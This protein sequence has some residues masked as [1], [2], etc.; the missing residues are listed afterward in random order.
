MSVFV[1]FLAP[2]AWA[3]PSAE[4]L[5]SQSAFRT[6]DVFQEVKGEP[7][8]RTLGSSSIHGDG[9]PSSF[10][11]E[12][13]QVTAVGQKA[14]LQNTT[15]GSEE[16]QNLVQDFVASKD[17]DAEEFAP[18]INLTALIPAG[19]K[20]AKSETAD[21]DRIIESAKAEMAPKA[22]NE[23]MNVVQA[24]DEAI[25]KDVEKRDAADQKVLNQSEPILDSVTALFPTVEKAETAPAAPAQTD[26]LDSLRAEVTKINQ[27]QDGR[28]PLLD[29]LHGLEADLDKHG[30]QSKIPKYDARASKQ[31]HGSGGTDVGNMNSDVDK[32]GHHS[33]PSGKN[34]HH[35]RLIRKGG[36]DDVQHVLSAWGAY[37]HVLGDDPS[38]SFQWNGQRAARRNV[39]HHHHN[40]ST[41]ATRGNHS[42]THSNRTD[43]ISV[44][45]DLER[46]GGRGDDHDP[47]VGEGEE[48]SDEHPPEKHFNHGRLS[49]DSDPGV[50]EGEDHP[51]GDSRKADDHPRGKKYEHAKS[52]GFGNTHA[53]HSKKAGKG[54]HEPDTSDNIE[55]AAPETEHHR[56]GEVLPNISTRIIGSVDF[57]GDILGRTSQMRRRGNSRV[58]PGVG[59]NIHRRPKSASK[60]QKTQKTQKTAA[61]ADAAAETQPAAKRAPE[62]AAPEATAHGPA[63]PAAQKTTA[64][65]Q[66]HPADAPAEPKPKA[67]EGP[68]A[69]ADGPAAEAQ[70]STGQNPQAAAPEPKPK[71]AEEDPTASTRNLAVYERGRAKKALN[72]AQ[73]LLHKM[74]ESL[75]RTPTLRRA[76]P[77]PSDATHPAETPTATAAPAGAGPAA[78]SASPVKGED[79]RRAYLAAVAASDESSEVTGG[80]SAAI[81]QLEGE[82]QDARSTERSLEKE[83]LEAEQIEVTIEDAEDAARN[84]VTL[85][86]DAIA[87]E[88]SRATKDGS[89]HGRSDREPRR[90]TTP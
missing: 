79:G 11:E 70:P 40:A 43:K 12:A 39:S 61:P 54:K 14:P 6:A 85:L 59:V 49:D 30:E 77:A 1:V 22:P 71:T 46:R 21:N 47:G 86:M 90:T 53:E 66:Q 29:S 23:L 76:L 56:R 38:K 67:P 84:R 44:P 2:F 62:S 13:S 26:I 74:D 88:R 27:E 35:G 52:E 34:G 24:T 5:L 19:L 73:E 69:T 18:K 37:S 41:N 83:R 57:A 81:L 33:P 3:A 89:Q 42:P 45:P 75:A 4:E 55:K 72:E 17:K 25:S 68:Q 80:N 32:P 82:L 65:Q 8:L 28:G 15:S 7:T 51:E 48:K 63:E 9:A 10:A 36:E 58:D 16:L 20:E 31:D 60:T 50:A 87:R 78:G 64:G